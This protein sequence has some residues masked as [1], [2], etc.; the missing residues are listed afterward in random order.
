M[1]T[2]NIRYAIAGHAASAWAIGDPLLNARELGIETDTGKFKIGDGAATWNSL[3]YMNFWTTWA[4]VDGKPSFGALALSN[5]VN[6]GDWSGADLDIANGGTG[7]SSASAARS[8]LGLAIGTN[9]QAYSANLAGWSGLSPTAPTFTSSATVA[10]ASGSAYFYSSRSAPS[11]GQVGFR[12]NGGTGGTDWYIYQA[13]NSNDLQVYGL[14]GMRLLVNSVGL[15][16]T[17][18]VRTSTATVATLPTASSSGVG[19]R[20]F[21]TDALSPVFGSAVTGGGAVKVPV[22]SDGSTWMV[23]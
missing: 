21:V 23:G 17:G 7:A 11:T 2:F 6:N 13:I 20:H 1:A 19:A 4:R 14:S 10:P 18:S 5:T 9:V 16:V 8:N 22:Y 3:P 12:M 15:V